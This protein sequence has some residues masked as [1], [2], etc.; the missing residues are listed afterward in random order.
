MGN[1]AN[2]NSN[3]LG[4]IDQCSTHSSL[5][6][7][8]RSHARFLPQSRLGNSTRHP[9]PT[10]A[11]G[12]ASKQIGTWLRLHFVCDPSLLPLWYAS[13]LHGRKCAAYSAV[14]V[15]SPA[16][17]CDYTFLYLRYSFSFF[18]PRVARTT[19]L[20]TSAPTF[21]PS[22]FTTSITNDEH[23][24]TRL[25]CICDLLRLTAAHSH[26]AAHRIWSET[27]NEVNINAGSRNIPNS[28]QAHCLLQHRAAPLPVESILSH[29]PRDSHAWR[30]T[31]KSRRCPG[32]SQSLCLPPQRS[33]TTSSS[34]V[35]TAYFA[36]SSCSPPA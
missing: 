34:S 8:P 24:R 6:I 1:N 28:G 14:L 36:H 4:R 29:S 30:S 13:L 22:N 11:A 2:D 12:R 3:S 21:P 16:R 31:F 23:S 10:P 27:K 5:W 7:C 15:Y 9:A 33:E 35:V 17:H 20:F 26:S 25:E 19:P 32:L 18:R